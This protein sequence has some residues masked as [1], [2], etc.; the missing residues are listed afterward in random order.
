M[1][2]IVGPEGLCLVGPALTKCRTI[3]KRKGEESLMISREWR[4]L[5]AEGARQQRVRGSRE[6][7][8]AEDTRAFG[9]DDGDGDGDGGSFLEKEGWNLRGKAR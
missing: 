9:P 7:E 8:A 4:Q 5:A 6:C 3:T 2:K 1:R